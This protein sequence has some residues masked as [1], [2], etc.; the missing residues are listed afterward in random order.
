VAGQSTQLQIAAIKAH[1]T[2]S[3]IVPSL[4]QSFDPSGLLDAS[5]PSVGTIS[6]GQLLTQA[7]VK[8]QPTLLLTPANS[9]VITSG[10]M[11]VAMV[12]AGPVGYDESKGQ[13]RHWLVNSAA[14]DSGN[15]TIDSA[16]VITKYAGPAPPNGDGPHRYVILVYSQPSGFKAPSGLTQPGTGVALYNFPQYVQDSGLGQLMGATYFDVE[17]GTATA[18]LSPTSAVVSSTLTAAGSGAS[19]SGSVTG[20]S[21]AASSTT[22]STKNSAASS[23]QA[24]GSLT[25]FGAVLAFFL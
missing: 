9:S 1:F 25:F 19:G 16:T 15:V 20:S 3:G 23:C 17:T 22:T 21:A 6:P 12:D 11:T 18:S 4:F 2:Q 14:V 5:F 13:T 24:V 8:P 7:Q 10:K